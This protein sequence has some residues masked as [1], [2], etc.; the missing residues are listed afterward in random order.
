MPEIVR[1]IGLLTALPT[2]LVLLA[3]GL[4]QVTQTSPQN[5]ILFI[6]GGALF[7]LSVPPLLFG[8]SGSEGRTT[9]DRG[10]KRSVPT[11]AH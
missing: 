6:I 10:A 1:A 7:I 8:G 4:A 5:W 2:S 11:R 3:M 9:S